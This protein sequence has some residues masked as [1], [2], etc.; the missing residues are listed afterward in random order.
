M[1]NDRPALFA[2]ERQGLRELGRAL[3]RAYPAD[4]DTP[5]VMLRLLGRIK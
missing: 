5:V 2:P 4:P 3:A 1:P